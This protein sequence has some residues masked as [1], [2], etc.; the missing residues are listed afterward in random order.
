MEGG[1]SSSDR[2]LSETPTWEV[3]A[4]CFALVVHSL[5]LELGIHHASHVIFFFR[6]NRISFHTILFDRS[7]FHTTLVSKKIVR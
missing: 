4:V 5:L 1:G 6:L 2:F 3:E 7:R